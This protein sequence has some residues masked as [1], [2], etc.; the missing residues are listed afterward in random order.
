MQHKT[1]PKQTIY[2]VSRGE[3]SDYAVLCCFLFEDDAQKFVEAFNQS[4]EAGCYDA[5]VEPISMYGEGKQP[6]MRCTYS[7]E[8]TLNDDGYVSRTRYWEYTGWD[9]EHESLRRPKAEYVRAPC[10]GDM[11]GYLRVSGRTRQGVIQVTSDKIAAFKAGAWKP[12][13]K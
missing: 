8:T 4:E 9:F 13:V 11:A 1:P 3:Y 6:T 10:L 2:A 5:R 7:S 12:H